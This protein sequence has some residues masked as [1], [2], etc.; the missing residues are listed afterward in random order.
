MT[1]RISTFAPKS[2]CKT[3][4][5]GKWQKACA[6][7]K[8][9]LLKMEPDGSI[10]EIMYLFFPKH[11]TYAEEQLED[12]QGQRGGRANEDKRRSSY[13]IGRQKTIS[14]YGRS[15]NPLHTEQLRQWNKYSKIQTSNEQDLATTNNSGKQWETQSPR[16][17]SKYKLLL[18]NLRHKS[19]CVAIIEFTCPESSYTCPEYRCILHIDA[20]DTCMPYLLQLHMLHKFVED[21]LYMYGY[22]INWNH[23][24]LNPLTKTVFHW[25]HWHA[26]QRHIQ[27][28]S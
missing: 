24:Y 13:Y 4:V 7:T 14:K 15:N 3:L 25:F 17:P 1:N 28:F 11:G 16:G 21:R 26:S 19:V 22:E 12:K 10:Y 9:M 27:K 8:N 6:V 5:Q 2:A 18:V 23:M 20:M